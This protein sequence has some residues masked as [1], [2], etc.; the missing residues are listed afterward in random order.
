MSQSIIYSEV[1]QQGRG[2]FAWLAFLGLLLAMGAYAFFHVEHTGHYVTGMNNQVVWGIPHVFAIFLIVAASGALNLGSMGTVF[3]NKT[4]QPLGRLSGLMAMALL[5]GGLAVLVLDLGRPDRLIVAMT[6]YNFKSI[7]AW[8]IILYNG[9]LALVG[10]YIWTMMDRKLSCFYKPVGYAAFFWRLILTTGTG[11]IFG[12]LVARQALDA[13]ILAPLFIAMSFALGLAFSILMIMALYR[14][15]ERPLGDVL[16][17]RMRYLLAIFI[18]VSLFFEIVRHL[19][20]LYMAEH[21][22]VEA[23]LLQDGLFARLF[24]DIQVILGALV[25]LALIF[26]PY[27]AA[28]R[29]SLVLASILVIM[30]GFAQLYSIVIGAQTY[31]LELFPGMEVESSFFDAGFT[32]YSPSAWELMLGFGGVAVTLVMITLGVRILRFLPTSLADDVVK[33]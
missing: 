19:T 32:S 16:V 20:N 28:Y 7:F 25:P 22:G 6:T 12:F 29:A 2:F 5:I 8:N 23:W 27:F 15:S 18:G 11:S 17:N 14:W 24:W 3:N 4:Y 21:Q 1:R 31:P 10:L 30:G 33:S 9:F 26:I 13:A